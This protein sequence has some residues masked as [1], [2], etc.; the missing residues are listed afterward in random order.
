M[1]LVPIPIAVP[2]WRLPLPLGTGFLA[3]V[4][5]LLIRPH[6]LHLTSWLIL[7]NWNVDST[8]T[9]AYVGA[10]CVLGIDVTERPPTY[11]PVA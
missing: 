8:L 9:L 2:R 11:S 1:L 3:R 4:Y 6:I 5:N 7:W 10:E